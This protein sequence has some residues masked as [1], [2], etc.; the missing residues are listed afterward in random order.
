GAKFTDSV[1]GAIY[2]Q[3][4]Y[5][6]N[7]SIA[8][9]GVHNVVFVATQNDSIYAFD[10]DT[11]GA[12]LW[13]TSFINPAAGVTAV[14]TTQPWQS[15]VYPQI[16]ITGTPVIDQSTGTLYVV[17]KTEVAT[18]AGPK[19]FYSLHGLDL[20]SGAEK[21]NGGVVIQPSVPGR[22][23]GHIKGVVP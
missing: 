1:D 8:G 17:A 22:G 9:K 14:P 20:S 7:V 10:A 21:F 3:P 23:A 15:D 19:D 12:P 6:A 18:A 2:A 13:Q 11:P 5:M 4:L 16:G